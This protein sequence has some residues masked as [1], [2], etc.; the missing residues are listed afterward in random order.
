[1]STVGDNFCDGN[2]PKCE[3]G[4]CFDSYGDTAKDL[5][6]YVCWAGMDADKN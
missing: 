4:Q 5:V 2:C 3:S 6:V 1:M